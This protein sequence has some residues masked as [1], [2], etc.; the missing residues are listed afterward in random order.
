MTDAKPVR[1]SA[2]EEITLPIGSDHLGVFSLNGSVFVA[3]LMFQKGS[4][5]KWAVSLNIGQRKAG[6]WIKTN[7]SR[8]DLVHPALLGKDERTTFALSINTSSQEASFT[9][10][11][12]RDL[13]LESQLIAPMPTVTT[14]FHGTGQQ[15]VAI[16]A[17]GRV[18]AEHANP[19]N[20]S[21]KLYSPIANSLVVMRINNSEVASSISDSGGRYHCGKRFSAGEIKN[22]RF[23]LHAAGSSLTSEI[24]VDNS[25]GSLFQ[26]S[27]N[28][29][30]C[31]PSKEP[32]PIP[33]QTD[34]ERQVQMHL[35]GAYRFMAAGEIESRQ[36]QGSEVHSVFQSAWV[37]T[38][39]YSSGYRELSLREGDS[40]VYYGGKATILNST[41][42]RFFISGYGRFWAY[43]D[44]RNQFYLA[45][46]QSP[47]LVL[48]DGHDYISEI[49]F[50]AAVG[51]IDM[52]IPIM[53]HQ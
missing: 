2:W 35:V 50:A 16:V 37:G 52:Q 20:S 4:D 3:W 46:R 49:C 24:P 12:A 53:G 11:G 29:D 21:G 7:Q 5:G 13:K 36:A 23:T 45:G 42:G 39:H 34:P 25:S 27:H 19:M 30:F 15:I 38:E 44:L 9:C 32:F 8:T 43:R 48:Q 33:P 41:P 1:C 10:W 17:T 47:Y 28:H 26:V 51:D 40:L 18:L 14:P 31:V 22:A 6:A